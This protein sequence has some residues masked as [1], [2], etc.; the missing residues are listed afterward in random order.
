M[1]DTLLL[2]GVAVFLFGLVPLLVV[3]RRLASAALASAGVTAALLLREVYGRTPSRG[4][5]IAALVALALG[6]AA[7]WW[8]LEDRKRSRGSAA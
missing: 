4:L 1:G 3:H 7:A 2:R 6:V 5:A 8:H